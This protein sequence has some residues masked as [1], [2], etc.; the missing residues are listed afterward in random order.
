MERHAQFWD[1]ANIESAF[2]RLEARI[3]YTGL[4]TYLAGGRSLIDTFCYVPQNPHRPDDREVLL[5]HFKKH[6]FFVRTKIGQK[7]CGGQWKC[8]F[9]VEMACDILRFVEYAKPDTIAVCSGDRDMKAVYQ[10]V[11]ERGV[12]VEVAATRNSFAWEILDAASSFIDL[13]KVIADQ[14]RVSA[15]ANGNGTAVNAP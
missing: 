11:R 13:G 5:R 9:D 8:N 1:L 3:D 10:S 7:R 6:G 12:R 15:R 14:R 4:R 2:R